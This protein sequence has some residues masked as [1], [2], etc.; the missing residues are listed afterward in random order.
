MSGVWMKKSKT[1]S[2]SGTFSG[3]RVNWNLT[4]SPPLF[5][6]KRQR[7]TERNRYNLGQFE[8]MLV[9]MPRWNVTRLYRNYVI[10]RFRNSLPTAFN[11]NRETLEQRAFFSPYIRRGYYQRSANVSPSSASD[12]ERIIEE[13]WQG[14]KKSEKKADT[15]VIYIRAIR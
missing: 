5:T 15:T 14:R 10:V 6:D 7:K 8:L 11:R 9:K 1:G 4:Y 12:D 13:E 2:F 3:A